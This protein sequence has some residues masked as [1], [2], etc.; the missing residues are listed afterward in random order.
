ML[1]NI[2]WAVKIVNNEFQASSVPTC[3]HC[4]K[5]A[6]TV[7]MSVSWGYVNHIFFF[8]T[9]S[10]ENGAA[11]IIAEDHC[12]ASRWY[13]NSNFLKC[14]LLSLFTFQLIFLVADVFVNLRSTWRLVI[15]NPTKN[16]N[17]YPSIFFSPLTTILS[18]TCAILSGLTC[19]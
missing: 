12:I 11:N 16:K 2:N 8:S 18:S 9:L 17:S 5:N 19:K 3:G 13:Q 14:S 6:E 15:G 7:S 10:T 4:K 1:T